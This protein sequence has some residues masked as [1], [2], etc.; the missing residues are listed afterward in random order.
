MNPGSTEPE[1]LPQAVMMGMVTGYWTTQIVATVATLGLADQLADGPHTAVELADRT[2]CDVAGLHR[3][4]RG[5]VTLGLM[6]VA[7]SDSHGSAPVFVGTGLLATLRDNASE[8]LRNVAVVHGGAAHWRSWAR[9]LDAVRT[10]APQAVA[11]LGTDVWA[12][13]LANPVEGQAFFAAMTELTGSITAE[14]GHAIDVDDV[15]TVVDVGGADGALLH[16]LLHRNATARGIVVDLPEAAESAIAAAVAQRHAD[17]VEVMSRSFFDPLPAGDLLLLKAVLHNWDDEA[18]VRILTRCR[19]ALNPG[20]RVVVAEFPL[21]PIDDPGPAALHDLNML[22][23]LGG[24]ERDLGE[25]DVL[26]T[27]AGLRRSALV[28]LRGPLCLIEAVAA[29]RPS[30]G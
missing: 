22:T 11:A 15:T 7:T 21:G 23:L 8:S 26:F 17:R 4:L 16:V 1:P 2:G 18:C 28:P 9:L 10:G 19:E 13:F 29:R 3:L 12:H 25:Y 30:S 14:A 6:D 20:G 27:A 24:R 5:C